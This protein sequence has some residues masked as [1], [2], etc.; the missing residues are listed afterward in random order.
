MTTETKRQI[1]RIALYG[2][3]I[4]AITTPA[5]AFNQLGG[6]S[7]QAWATAT[8]SI[9]VLGSLFSIYS[10]QRVIE[11]HEDAQ[12]PY[13]VPSIDTRSRT[14]LVQFRLAN[15]GGS[16]AYDVRIDWF[17]PLKTAEGD[18]VSLGTDGVIS[19]L[20]PNE[21]AFKFLGAAVSFFGDKPSADLT[22]QGTIRFKDA[23]GESY[24]RKFQT[25][26]DHERESMMYV[27]KEEITHRELQ[28]I[29]EKLKKIGE[30]LEQ[31]RKQA[32]RE[33]DDDGSN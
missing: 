9:A 3:G 18:E 21:S 11:M 24:V 22:S 28:R 5:V 31:I 23:T 10:S 29:P 32:D 25:S 20:L 1:L 30:E 15:T 4:F 27:D 19:S 7:I 17:V 14:N 2:A 13:L 8:A 16:T 33:V 26:G 6:Q 12:A